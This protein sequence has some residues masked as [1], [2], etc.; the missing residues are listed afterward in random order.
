MVA[1][2]PVVDHSVVSVRGAPR[3]CWDAP[4]EAGHEDIDSSS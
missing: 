4:I 2:A 1:E 3:R